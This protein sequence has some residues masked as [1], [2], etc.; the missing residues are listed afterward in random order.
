MQDAY[1]AVQANP[2]AQGAVG[3]LQRLVNSLLNTSNIATL[4]SLPYAADYTVQQPDGRRARLSCTN[5]L[6]INS[7]SVC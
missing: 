2:M 5:V 1:N 4:C 6:F 3:N 7:D